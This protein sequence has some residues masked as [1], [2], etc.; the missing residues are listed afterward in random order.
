MAGVPLDPSNRHQELASLRM[1]VWN[2]RMS[3]RDFVHRA[4][5]L[6]L[7]TAAISALW[8]TY[9]ARPVNARGAVH[10]GNPFSARLQTSETPTP[11][12]TLRFARAEDSDNLDPV[13]ND[14]NVNIWIFMNIYDQLIRVTPDGVNLEPALAESWDISQ[15][16]LTYTFHLRQGVKFSDG[17]P[18]TSSDVKYS[19]ERAAND[20]A[21][22]WTFTLTALQRDANGQVTGIST[23]DDHTVVITL[24]QPWAPFLSDMAMFNVS[25]ISEA[26][27]KGNEARLVEECMGTGPF[28]LAEWRKGESI[29]L[30][31]NPNY[32]EP[33]LPL[34]DEIFVSV[35][36][37]D[38][39]RIL[40]LQAGE[41]DAMYNVPSSRV[42]EL[43]QD[44]NLQVLEFPST[45]TAYITLNTRIA[46][47]DDVNTRLALAYATD[48]Q[49]LVDV[50]LF[51]LG[52]VATSFMP[53]GALYWNDQLPGFPYDL[54]KAKEYLSKSKAPDGF[55]LELTFQG[56]D[57]EVQQLGAA[58]KDMWSKIGVD[59]QLNPVEQGLYSDMYNNHTFQAMYNYWT[60]DIIDPDELV[61]YALLP[62][63]SEA[64]QTGW[65]N[66]EAIDL[67]KRGAAELDPEKRREIYFRI[68]EIYAA[69]SPML[70]LYH[71]P[72]LDAMTTNAHDFGHPPTGQWVWKRTWI[73][74]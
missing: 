2:G 4:T 23:P 52:T 44:P 69:E 45:F 9:R 35:V 1:D 13:T 54:E 19:L 68:Q 6:G 41:I 58:L 24:S 39:T 42:A 15:D 22:T 29:T 53:K 48:R 8:T 59:L 40:Q 63:S 11:G 33:G 55:K 17:T 65:Q 30:A 28:V 51:G 43:R 18:L 34:L 16:G 56:G 46:P 60:N 5:S 64:F 27:A 31:R 50:V 71:K 32:W 61:S 38:N 36:P 57:A 66:Q 62:E 47:L 21:Q 70:Y 12:G 37:D 10:P 3:R 49:T 67:A 26:F 72:Y 74:R 14:G 20:P 7:S 25:I 73:S